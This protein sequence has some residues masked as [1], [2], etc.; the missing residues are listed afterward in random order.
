MPQ[1]ENNYRQAILEVFWYY[2]QRNRALSKLQKR[3]HML[4]RWREYGVF[5][6]AWWLGGINGVF[7]GTMVIGRRDGVLR[8]SCVGR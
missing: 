6:G 3:T 4:S 2:R 5:G 8:V 7:R 1:K